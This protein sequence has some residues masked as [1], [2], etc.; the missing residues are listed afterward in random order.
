M[1]VRDLILR[2]LPATWRA[3]VEAE[4]REWHLICGRCGTAESVWS[5]GGLRWKAMGRALTKAYCHTCAQVTPHHH[6][7]RK[8][9]RRPGREPTNPA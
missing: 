8:V 1:M 9:V 5:R 6:E 4:S 3:A 7:R 2:L